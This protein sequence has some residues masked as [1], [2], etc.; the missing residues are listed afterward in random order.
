MI[1]EIL[2]L[3][4]QYTLIA[5]FGLIIG[6]FLNVYI[7]RLHTGK[8]LSGHSHCL[9]CGADLRAYEL[10]PLISYLFLRGRCRTCGCHIPVRYFIVELLTA[11]LFLLAYQLTSDWFE[12]TFLLVV[13]SLLV[14]ITVYDIRHYIIPDDLTA[15][16]TLV[17]LAWYGWLIY[18]GTS[19]LVVGEVVVAALAGAAFFFVLWFISKGRWLGFGDV[20]LAFP[21]GLVA[22]PTLVFSMIVYSFWLGAAISLL[23]VGLGKLVRGQFRLGMW[24]GRLTIKSVVPFAPFMIAGCLIVLFTG[25]NVLSFFTSF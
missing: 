25:Y 17:T 1:F 23:L 22:G 13:L 10:I 21:L 19:W 5:M 12:L 14:V 6:S 20:K 18:T 15:K 2:P 24:P 3:G 9:S 8:S 4:Y 11:G 7:Y 16:L